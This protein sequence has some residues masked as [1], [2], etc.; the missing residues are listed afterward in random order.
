MNMNR[1]SGHL[2]VWE[3]VAWLDDV[4]GGLNIFDPQEEPTLGGVALLE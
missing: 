4:C 1:T 2:G 3:G